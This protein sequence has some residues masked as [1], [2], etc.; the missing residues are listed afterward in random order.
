MFVVDK[1]EMDVILN[2][3]EVRKEY[4]YV[5]SITDLAPFVVKYGVDK[6]M[7][8]L[9]MCASSLMH[10]TNFGEYND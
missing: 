7:N 9:L 1:T 2:D 4:E 10:P 3:E 8:D 5:M 6:V